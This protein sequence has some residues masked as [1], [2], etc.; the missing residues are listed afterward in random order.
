MAAVAVRNVRKMRQQQQNQ[1][2]QNH[3]VISKA[4]ITTLN[5]DIVEE[6]AGNKTEICSLAEVKLHAKEWKN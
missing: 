3:S 5:V 4:V 1:Q 2:Q 6:S